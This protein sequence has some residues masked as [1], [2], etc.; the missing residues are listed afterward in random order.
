MLVTNLLGRRVVRRGERKDVYP[1]Q[2]PHKL[3]KGNEGTIVA[4]Y[5][6]EPREGQG[7]LLRF[8]VEHQCERTTFIDPSVHPDEVWLK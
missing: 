2:G 8:A 6:A 1:D 7:S 4:V 3:G 5:L